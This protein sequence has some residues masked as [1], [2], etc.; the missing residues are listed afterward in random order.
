MSDNPRPIKVIKKR[1]IPEL[2]ENSQLGEVKLTKWKRVI[3]T[4]REEWLKDH[5]QASQLASD[6]DQASFASVERDEQE[7]AKEEAERE[8]F[9][10]RA[11]G[12]AG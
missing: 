7:K 9:H 8:E 1:D 4:T 5:E 11:K 3:N 6:R 2:K 10:A 12:C